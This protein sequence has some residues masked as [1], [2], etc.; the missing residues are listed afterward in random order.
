MPRGDVLF[1][2][3]ATEGVYIVNTSRIQGLDA[4]NPYD[5]SRAEIEGRR[6]CSQ[7]FHF[8]KSHCPGFEKAIFVGTGP[9]VGVRETRHVRGLY[10][11]TAED[12]ANEARFPD[13]IAIGG[14]P[15]D[16]HSPT[17]ESTQSVHLRDNIAYQIPMRS[18]LV[19]NP[20]NLIFVGRS[21]SATHEAAAAFRVTPIAM[22]IG[23]AGGTLAAL[24]V[25]GKSTTPANTFPYEILR[26]KLEADGAFLGEQSP[27]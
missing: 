24:S 21:I 14:Y 6:Q 4:T 7:I 3:T 16:I 26:A 1:F 9:Q 18:L 13:P 17:G 12:L 15:I 22:A 5:L 2:E 11:L 20:C 19:K 27:D 23:Q 25:L 10:T 8:L